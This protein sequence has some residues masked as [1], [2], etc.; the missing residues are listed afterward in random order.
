MSASLE[1][2]LHDLANKV[3]SV[4]GAAWVLLAATQDESLLYPLL[5][6]IERAN[7]IVWSM[8]KLTSGDRG[9]QVPDARPSWK[10][11]HGAA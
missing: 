8:Q 10:D 1:E 4:G 11:K 3:S 2:L 6:E 7:E 9:A 5:D